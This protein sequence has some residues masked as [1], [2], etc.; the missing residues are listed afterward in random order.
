[1]SPLAFALVLASAALHAI[2]SATIKRS[3]H[4][5]AFNWLQVVLGTTG[6]WLALPWIPWASV[7]TEVWVTMGATGV[8]HSAYMYW[9]ARAYEG[10]DLSL[11][12]PIARSTPAF[13]PF[14]AVP[15]LG[16]EIRLGGAL[17][18]AVVVLGIWCVHLGPETRGSALRS[19]AARFAYLTLGATVVYSLLDKHAMHTLG[20]TENPGPLPWAIVYSL[21]YH[22]F[23][24]SFL[25][26][27]VVRRMGW[28]RL[29]AEI[30]P[31][32][33][34]AAMAAAISFVGYAL[35]LWAYESALA[36]YVVAVRQ[37]SVLFAVGLGIVWLGE[38]PGRARVWGAVLTVI[39]IAL[40]ARFG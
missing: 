8:A 17:G 5:L 35:I 22:A 7:P 3:G 38:R 39:G 40:I 15:L 11:V 34:T 19:Q 26:V 30:R 1:M 27:L 33:R 16:E 18:I 20:E 24:A 9:M 37:V 21:L 32:L 13:L 31:Q 6:L 36:S 2:W 25:T 12:Y 28:S 29:R 14:L 23:D 10:G 4:P